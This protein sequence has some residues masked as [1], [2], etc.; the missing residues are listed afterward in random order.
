MAM[1]YNQPKS[2]PGFSWLGINVGIKDNSLDFGVIASECKCSSAAVFT[3]N[4]LPG[5]PVIVGKEKIKNGQL[6]AV[7]VNSK[8]ANVAKCNIFKR[9]FN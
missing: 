1:N 8:N 2:V 9:K 5:A 4:N 6:Q 7:V 3:R